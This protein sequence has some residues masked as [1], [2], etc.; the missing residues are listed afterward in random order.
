MEVIFKITCLIAGCPNV[1]II[2][3]ILEDRMRRSSP[4]QNSKNYRLR[5]FA[6]DFIHIL[7]HKSVLK[8]VYP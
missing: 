2:L 6:L 3:L 5:T 7:K 8:Y 1:I 4:F